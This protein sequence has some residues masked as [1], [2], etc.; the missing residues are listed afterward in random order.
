MNKKLINEELSRI[1]EIM[2]VPGNKSLIVESWVDDLMDAILTSARK[3]GST[4]GKNA[5]Q[6]LAKLA[7]DFPYLKGLDAG[8]LKKIIAGGD[9]VFSVMNKIIKN[10]SDADLG[11]FAADIYKNSSDLQ[12]IATDQINGI[13]PSMAD[14][15][16]DL[17]GATKYVDDNIET[18]VTKSGV[19]ASDD[20][21]EKLRTQLK[22]D[23]LNNVSTVSSK[24]ATNVGTTV[25][26]TAEELAQEAKV[27]D[28]MSTLNK[29]DTVADDVTG[30][31]VSTPSKIKQA[32]LESSEFNK[33][34]DRLPARVRRNV[35]KD[36]FAQQIAS[37]ISS[38]AKVA[39]DD[40]PPQLWK[41]DGGMT[42]SQK[43]AIFDNATKKFK[44]QYPSAYQNVRSWLVKR[45]IGNRQNWVWVWA[46]ISSTYLIGEIAN[47][48]LPDL[49]DVDGPGEY[50]K[51]ILDAT[52]KAALAPIGVGIVADVA[53]LDIES[54]YFNTLSSFRDY[55]VDKQNFSKETVATQT[56]P[57][58]GDVGKYE[59]KGPDG[60][61]RTY[62][63]DENQ[64][65][66]FPYDPTKDVNKSQTPNPPNPPNPPT[67]NTPN[68]GSLTATTQVQSVVKKIPGFENATVK[69]FTFKSKDN[70]IETYEVVDSLGNKGTLTYD[71]TTGNGTI[72]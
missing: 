50:T 49:D 38:R 68:T 14:G 4:L 9:E 60:V 62:I 53:G 20:L 45:G 70:N 64:G 57:V 40:L 58:F 15:S 11:D 66:F 8:D 43:L 54:D 37:E 39:V 48:A 24:N 25:T 26:K 67:P 55:L 27:N 3:G 61:L 34:Y 71:I 32:I 5:T 6:Q 36:Q 18:W 19:E 17:E 35:T 13:K 22:N 10:M 29:F 47:G 52:I 7:E 30:E 51:A 41:S 21:V 12:K 33:A 2:G 31:V 46:G 72:N 59:A 23:I 44:Q 28:I 42:Q 56:R 63:Y 16:L 1:W 69:S 65:T